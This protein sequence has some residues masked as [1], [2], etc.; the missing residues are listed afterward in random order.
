MYLNL[1]TQQIS[2]SYFLLRVQIYLLGCCIFQPMPSSIF[3][4]RIFAKHL[5]QHGTDFRP[6][7]THPL[8]RRMPNSEI[9]ELYR[10]H[11]SKYLQHTKEEINSKI[12][13]IGRITSKEDGLYAEL[14]DITGKIIKNMKMPVMDNK[15]MIILKDKEYYL[16]Q[17]L[18]YV[19][20]LIESKKEK[21]ISNTKQNNETKQISNT[22]QN[23]MLLICLTKSR[24]VKSNNKSTA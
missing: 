8:F 22:K 3:H 9:L 21:P 12:A 1:L 7:K 6:L 20:E 14:E 10:K 19:N 23:E 11:L 4:E 24:R 13:A 16:K 2:L 5:K 18:S 17:Q 15:M